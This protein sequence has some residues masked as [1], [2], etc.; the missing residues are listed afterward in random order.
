MREIIIMRQCSTHWMII[1]KRSYPVAIYNTHYELFFHVQDHTN[2]LL[3]LY[4]IVIF[5][6]SIIKIMNFIPA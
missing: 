3:K 1:S 4:S 5:I 6:L 2:I